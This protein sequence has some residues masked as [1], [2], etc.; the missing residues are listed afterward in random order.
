MT[1]ELLCRRYE[2]LKSARG[3]WEE[4][5]QEV[6]E[7]IFPRR[8][9]FNVMRTEGDK[10]MQ[11][12]YD[13]TGV[14]AL[15]LLASGLHGF[16]SNP[17]ARWFSI[18]TTNA[19]L[20]EIDAVREWLG[21]VED[22]IFA[23]MQS[24]DSSI[25]SHL[26][27]LYMDMGAFGTGIMFIGVGKKE[28]LLFQTRF[29]GECVIDE[30]SEGLVDTVLR[31]FSWGVRQVVQQWPDK[32]SEEIRKKFRDGKFD[33]PVELLHAVY[34]RADRDP[35]K[36]TAD[37]LPWASI[38]IEKKSRQPLQ[39]GGFE[40]FPYA[41]P[42]WYKATGE[43][44]G[45]SPAMTAL[46][47]VKMLQEMMKTTI[48]AAQKIV[49]PPLLV[50]DDAMIGPVRTIPGGLN[51]YRGER[52]IAP[53]QTGANIPISLEMMQD[54]RN[55]ILKTFYADI[56]QPAMDKQMTAYEYSKIVEQAMR[57]LGPVVGRMETELLGPLI[58][59]VFGI[60]LRQGVFPKQPP[61][62][63]GQEYTVEY[64]SPLAQSQKAQKV[65]AAI[66]MLTI[67]GQMSQFDPSIMGRFNSDGFLEWM[68]R[69]MNVDADL[70]L[71]DEEFAAKQQQQ[72]MAQAV[73]AAVAAAEAFQ[74][75]GAGAKAFA[76]AAVAGQGA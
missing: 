70:I 75:S 74:K 49:D 28:N 57:L 66:N 22:I 41:V 35:G 6:S 34:P 61:E 76:E 62:L 3:L 38:Y 50:P 21:D 36:E 54:L 26:H 48:R 25:T 10:R 27:E 12:V 23:K 30:N 29:L 64:I 51:F 42:R 5:W 47:D 46:P 69:E 7:V 72:Q 44:Y 2:A 59:R 33:E 40:E 39:E 18:R 45:R 1:P 24:P 15:E 37:N 71:D 14:Q 17:A 16:A 65:D 67:A 31:S 56:M 20:N 9:A 63:D 68:A 73:P 60:L 43:R 58:R 11:Q 13:G 4:H 32:V 53:L 8:A 19:A 52:E 55:R